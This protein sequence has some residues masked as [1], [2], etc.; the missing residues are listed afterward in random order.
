MKKI[1]RKEFYINKK[2]SLKDTSCMPELYN[3]NEEFQD[4]KYIIR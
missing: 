4:N 3:I 2:V 1:K